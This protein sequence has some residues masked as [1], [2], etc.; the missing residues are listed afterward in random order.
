MK[1]DI[2]AVL[3]EM[4]AR[5]IERWRQAKDTAAREDAHR[6]VSLIGAFKTQLTAIALDGAAANEAIKDQ[7]RKWKF[8]GL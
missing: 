8:P 6:H 7:D 4:D 2:D 1:E 3:S 5:Y